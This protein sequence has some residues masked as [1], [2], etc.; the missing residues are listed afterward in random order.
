MLQTVHV[1]CIT[2]FK[3]WIVFEQPPLNSKG[4]PFGLWKSTAHLNCVKRN[5]KIE[6]CAPSSA[7]IIL[8]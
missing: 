4:A 2:F 8:Q 6:Q 5:K 3:V 1:G 7:E